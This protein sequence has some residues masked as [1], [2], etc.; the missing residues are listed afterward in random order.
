MRPKNRA[1]VRT[2]LAEGGKK[3]MWLLISEL[4][5]SGADKCLCPANVN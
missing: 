1:F 2:A 5:T 3:K 4:K